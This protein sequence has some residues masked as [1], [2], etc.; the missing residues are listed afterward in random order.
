MHLLKFLLILYCKEFIVV[1]KYLNLL[2]KHEIFYFRIIIIIQK[3]K[4]IN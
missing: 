3:I 2:E 4:N 1:L